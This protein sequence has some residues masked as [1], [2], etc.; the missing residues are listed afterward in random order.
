MLRATEHG[1]KNDFRLFIGIALI[2]LLGCLI[3]NVIAAVQV[4]GVAGGLWYLLDRTKVVWKRLMEI[5]SPSHC[6]EGQL[7]ARNANG[8]GGK[9]PEYSI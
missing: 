9:L 7:Q 1:R 3:I 2:F 4:L 8:R 5:P 6:N